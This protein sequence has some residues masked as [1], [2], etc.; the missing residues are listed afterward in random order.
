MAKFPKNPLYAVAGHVK[1]QARR[2][3][4]RTPLGQ[5]FRS[6]SRTGKRSGRITDRVK[7]TIEK[8]QGA[9]GSRKLA[10]DLLSRTTAGRM[11]D[12]IERY[13]KDSG[14]MEAKLFNDL[15][16]SLGPIGRLVKTIAAPGGKRAKRG[17]GR[18]LQSAIDFVSA[19]HDEPEVIDWAKKILEGQGYKITKEEPAEPRRPSEEKRKTVDVDVGSGKS[20]RYRKDHPIVTGAMVPTPGSS[21][22]HSFGYHLDSETMYVRFKATVGGKKTQ[23]PGPL[24]EYAHVPPRIFL[25]FYDDAKN[26]EGAGVAVWDILRIRG[27]LSGHH[28]DYKLIGITMGYVPRKATLMPD[29]EWFR[30]REVRTPEGQKIKSKRP[31]QLVRPLVFRGEPNRAKPNRAKPNR[32]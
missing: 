26:G 14:S 32:G 17:L 24:Y 10:R 1:R 20:K 11:A 5:A 25:R 21:N 19:F 18:Q 31:N 16:E 15:L 4:D 30:Q 29:G 3:F 28:Y 9:A 6:I 8:Y 22:V 23:S 27:T 7:K 13:T 12:Q 2:E